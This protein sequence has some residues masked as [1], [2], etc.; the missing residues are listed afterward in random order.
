MQ[1]KFALNILFQTLDLDTFL[2]SSINTQVM[3]IWKAIINKKIWVNRGYPISF[4]ANISAAATVFMVIKN[5][6]HMTITINRIT[7][8][9]LF[10]KFR[11]LFFILYNF[12][13]I[14]VSQSP[15]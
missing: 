11:N 13:T 6:K 12:T 9:L 4:N 8:N 10:S 5:V 1:K 14:P 7:D 3:D 15:F 2:T